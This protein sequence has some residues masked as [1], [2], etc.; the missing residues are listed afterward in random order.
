VSLTG[1]GSLYSGG[2]SSGAIVV[3]SGGTLNFG[4]TDV[5][6]IHTAVPLPSL[7]IQ[8]GGL[9]QNNGAFFN[10][11]G[12]VALAAGNCGRSAAGTPATRRSRSAARCR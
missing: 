1:A 2:A 4:R 6:G 10:T 5:W 8:A 7:T 12:P 3:N 11:L 9:V